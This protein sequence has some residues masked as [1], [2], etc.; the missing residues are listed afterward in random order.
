MGWS[1][2]FYLHFNT[3]KIEHLIEVFHLLVGQFYNLIIILFC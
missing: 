3:H 1:K 2:S